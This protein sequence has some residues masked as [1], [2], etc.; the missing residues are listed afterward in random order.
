MQ[1][2]RVLEAADGKSEHILD[3]ST[4]MATS[5]SPNLGDDHRGLKRVRTPLQADDLTHVYSG[6]DSAAQVDHADHADAACRDF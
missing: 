2:R 5:S 6:D 4:T 3:S 1:R